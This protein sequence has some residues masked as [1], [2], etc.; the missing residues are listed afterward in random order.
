[1]GGVHISYLSAD[2][3]ALGYAT[4]ASGAWMTETVDAPGRGRS[5]IAVDSAG[6]VHIGYGGGNYATNASGAWVT[7]EVDPSGGWGPSIALDS[8]DKLHVCYRE[9][10]DEYNFLYATNAS[11][12][13]VREILDQSWGETCSIAL[14][15][16]D[17]VHIAYSDK[18]H[19]HM[20]A[21]NASGAWITETV[22]PPE[23]RIRMDPSIALDGADKA[24]M[25]YRSETC[26]LY[27]L[28]SSLVLKYAT[29]ASGSW[30]T[31]VASDTVGYG[32]D[33]SIS[34]DDTGTVYISHH[35]AAE[36]TL[37]L[38]SGTPPTS[39]GWGPASTVDNESRGASTTPNYFL[40]LTVPVGII[41]L[42]R[43]LNRR[44]RL[45]R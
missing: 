23:P 17:K 11:G 7:E 43:V 27:P 16:S 34:V 20:Y 26:P 40:F 1:L 5:S 15:S 41:L 10:S 6:S 32:D 8:D 18:D 44:Q 38:T 13:W 36:G 37:L 22:G 3:E 12:S 42:Q 24:H 31:W 9:F 39:S 21:T 29:N 30:E 33:N 35:G 2:G 4:N 45:S 14:D 25:S 19:A 28:C